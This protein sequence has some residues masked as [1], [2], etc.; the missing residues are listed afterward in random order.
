V[1]WLRS[2][3]LSKR[4]GR[5]AVE[6]LVRDNRSGVSPTE[7]LFFFSP[8]QIYVPRRLVTV[9][10]TPDTGCGD[11]DREIPIVAQQF[12]SRG[13]QAKKEERYTSNQK[14]KEAKC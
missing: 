3:F 12:V 13:R 7:S 2:I 4:I 1:S 8:P 5:K 14:D 6:E 9:Y 11:I 10:D